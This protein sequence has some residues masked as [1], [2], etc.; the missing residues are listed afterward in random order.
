[1]ETHR[2]YT[3]EAVDVLKYKTPAGQLVDSAL[4]AIAPRLQEFVKSIADRAAH[5]N[6]GIDDAAYMDAVKRGDTE[7]AERMVREAAARAFPD[8][9]V[10]GEDG[11]L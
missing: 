4:P 1:M 11:I 3:V 6:R 8:T 9:K 10:V 7:T 2:I 5:V